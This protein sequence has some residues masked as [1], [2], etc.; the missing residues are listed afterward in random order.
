MSYS[1][2][3]LT[4]FIHSIP[5]FFMAGWAVLVLLADALGESKSGR[6]GPLAILGL[7][8]ALGLCLSSWIDLEQPVNQLF[9]GM[10]LVDR[11]ALFFDVLFIFAAILTLLIAEAYLKEH[12]FAF[13][14]FHSLTLLVVTGMMLLVHAAN[15]VILLI[16]LEIMSLGTYTLVACWTGQKKSAEG[17]LK[18]F[19][20]GAIAS[21]FLI[22]GIALIYGAT[23]ETN[24]FKIGA[25]A[26]AQQG[27]RLFLVGMLMMMGALGFK[28]ALVPFHAWA[29]DAYEGAPTPVT[30]F[31][32]A[33]VKTAGFATLYRVFTVAFGAEAYVF[34]LGGTFGW[35]DIFKW[36]AI[37]T[38]IVGNFTALRQTNIKRMLAYS[39]I[40]HAGYLLIGVIASG[41][42]PQESSAAILYYLLSY[43][44][45]TLGAFGIIAWLGNVHQERV[46]LEDYRGLA[47]HHPAAA[48]AMTL[49]LLSL[50]GV[51]PTAG[52]FAKFYLFKAALGHEGLLSLVIIAVLNSV[53][54]VYYYLRPVV[55]MYFQESAAETPSTLFSPLQS[56]AVT[57]ALVLAAGFVL[58]L[59]I[60]PAQYLNWAQQSALSLLLL[61]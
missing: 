11:F 12:Q 29:P 54:S 59:G 3:P 23:G 32:A 58:V 22:Y 17:A 28:V 57:T 42:M 43:T 13:G 38:M 49:F 53:V 51:P 39:S 18:Y 52:F 33:A 61:Q 34:G 46:E 27:N 21:A 30:G 50:A 1:I 14:E 15:F 24:L 8:I 45:T 4:D 31:M 60:I 6:L 36:L 40:A 48:A 35:S 56:G 16:G 9:G 20:M 41:I 26:E 10:L 55:A 25:T 7:V 19:V 5:L 44:F 47:E 37:L 2:P